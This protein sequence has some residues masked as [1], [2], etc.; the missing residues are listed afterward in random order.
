MVG[1]MP[2]AESFKD[3]CFLFLNSLDIPGRATFAMT[4]S[5]IWRCRNE[6]FLEGTEIIARQLTHRTNSFLQDWMKAKHITT[7][8]EAPNAIPSRADGP[9][10]L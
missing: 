5:S 2:N 6:K 8:V 1:F 10:P 7:Q 9:Q 3:S 4:K